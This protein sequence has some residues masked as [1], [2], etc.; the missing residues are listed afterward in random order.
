MQENLPATTQ[1]GELVLDTSHDLHPDHLDPQHQ[2]VQQNLAAGIIPVA[3]A[4][5]V[6]LALIAAGWT[7]AVGGG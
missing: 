2:Q 5:F 4:A 6:I 3:L 7:L 1:P